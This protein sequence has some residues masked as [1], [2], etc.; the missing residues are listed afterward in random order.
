MWS[1]SNNQIEG[2]DVRVKLDTGAEVNVMPKRVYDQL[3]KC[4]K[5]ITKTSVKLHG[6]GGYDIPVIG[7]IR[8]ECSVNDVQKLTDF[9]VAQTKSKTILGLQSCRDMTL[10]KIMDKVNEK[11]TDKNT[12]DE[13]QKNI[14]EENV[15]RLSGKKGD[16]LK[17][18]ILKLYPKVFTS[19]GRLEQPYHTVRGEFNSSYPCT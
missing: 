10:V 1:N 19:L 14:T 2:S 16:D 8:L 17:Q 6:Y 13:N 15:K 9:H 12:D 7:T 3:K 11:S 18:K 4:N 5:K